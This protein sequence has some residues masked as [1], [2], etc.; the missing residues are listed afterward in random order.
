M[1]GVLVDFLDFSTQKS[2]VK[3]LGDWIPWIPKNLGLGAAPG[4][5]QHLLPVA[6]GSIHGDVAPEGS[7]AALHDGSMVIGPRLLGSVEMG[8]RYTRIVRLKIRN[9]HN[10]NDEFVY[11]NCRNHCTCV[12]CHDII[13]TMNSN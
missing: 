4:R 6:L 12:D 11:Q 13:H 9:D 3:L 8:P 7:S 10:D 1:S 2:Y 5:I